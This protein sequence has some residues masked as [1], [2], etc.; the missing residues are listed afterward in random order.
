MLII[1]P[2]VNLLALLLLYR[3][4]CSIKR[5]GFK[6]LFIILSSYLCTPN[7]FYKNET[8]KDN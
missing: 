7:L 6:I 1:G 3:V 2:T 4:E 5:C 8:I